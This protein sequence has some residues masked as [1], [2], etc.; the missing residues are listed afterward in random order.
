MPNEVEVATVVVPTLNGSWIRP[1]LLKSLSTGK[2][3][4]P[5]ANSNLALTQIKFPPSS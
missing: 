1:I 5:S 2:S 3:P 4:E